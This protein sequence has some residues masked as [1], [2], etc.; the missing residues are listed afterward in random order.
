[1]KL[2][3]YYIN[4]DRSHERRQSI[5]A[6]LERLSLTHVFARFPAVDGAAETEQIFESAGARSV[7]ACRRSHEQVIAQSAPDTI[8]IVLEDDVE[9]SEGFARIVTEPVMRGFVAENP[10]VDMVFLDCCPY[11]ASMPQLLAEA[12][13]HLPGRRQS[14]ASAERNHEPASV[15]I[16]DARDRYAYCA[17]AYVVT[18]RGKERLTALFRASAHADRTPIDSLFLG[19][20]ASGEINARIFVPFLVSPPLDV[21]ES[22]IPYDTVGQPPVDVQENRW[23]STVRRLLFAGETRVESGSPGQPPGEPVRM[24]SEYAA[25][26]ALYEQLRLMYLEQRG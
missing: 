24:S 2:D 14:P 7:W 11:V 17:A 22:T 10:S 13:R 18:P 12:E 26:M 16:L 3:G 1:M 20:I 19:W 6:Q 25:G 9:F 5:D 21:F 4:L 8:T 15:S 23:V